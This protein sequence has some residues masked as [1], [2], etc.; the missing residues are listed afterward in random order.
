[1]GVRYQKRIGGNKGFGLNLSGSGISSSYRTKYGSV[2]SK[3]FSIRSGIP[4]LSFRSG[5]GRGKDKGV[6]ALIILGLIV[7]GFAIYYSIVILYNFTLF[8][9]WTITETRKLILREY[10][11]WQERKE[12]KKFENLTKIENE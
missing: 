4:G 3:G 9:L 11:L 6:T 7:A 5:Y 12:L 2:G 10:Y 8:L 1:M